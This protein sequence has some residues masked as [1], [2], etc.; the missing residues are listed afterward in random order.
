MVAQQLPVKATTEVISLVA[1]I[2][3]ITRGVVAQELLVAMEHQQEEETVETGYSL[4]LQE[5]QHI[6]PV[7]VVAGVTTLYQVLEEVLEA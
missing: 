6:T 2:N 4:L 5:Q 7:V 1:L 3:I